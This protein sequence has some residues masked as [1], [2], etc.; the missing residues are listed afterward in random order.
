M[1]AFALLISEVLLITSVLLVV[2]FLILNVDP[3]VF[4]L[5]DRGLWR[6][7][8]AAA[9]IVFGLYFEDLYQHI[10]VK[11]RVLLMQQLC[12]VM[13]IALL[14][15]GFISYVDDGLRMP[16][17]LMVPAGGALI[18]VLF[19]WRVAYSRLVLRVVGARRILLV[20]LS[21]IV[22][23][24]A[25]H[26]AAHP[27]L[28]LAV[29]GHVD[30]GGGA[31]GPP[32]TG[33]RLGPLGE[34]Q[35]V[36]T[37]VRPDLLV[38][39]IADRRGQMPI[40]GLLQL[41]YGG[42]AIEEASTAY[43]QIFG[44]VLLSGLSPSELL[45]SGVIQPHAGRQIL[46][47]LVHGLLALAAALLTA[48]LLLLA[49]IALRL[50]G[51]GPLLSR[52][53]CAGLRGKP[54]RLYRFRLA[55]R[56]RV[57]GFVGR[58]RLDG[59]PQLW[60]VLRGDLWLVGPQPERTEFAAVLSGQIPF[61][62]QRYAGKPGMTGWAQINMPADRPEDTLRRMEY[63]LYYLKNSTSALD[64]YILM[65]TLRDL[66]LAPPLPAAVRAWHTKS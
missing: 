11:S 56:R 58:W 9:S 35:K 10:D 43:E 16:L 26:I 12:L 49:A 20:G 6:I 63:D 38:V 4:L 66:L 55:G 18:A 61:Y 15:Q 45:L 29:A 17:R 32:G 46:R 7:G 30:D 27:E 54:F 22:E 51:G 41:R 64:A 39:G 37:E 31:A 62:R 28:G 5:A 34:L 60:N 42:L 33:N 36:A 53:P 23:E 57:P 3:A 59:L 24:L 14:L 52:T 2:T 21:P 40:A 50:T 19:G 1:G 25:A 47:T 65:H 48:P 13:G 44:R 8:L